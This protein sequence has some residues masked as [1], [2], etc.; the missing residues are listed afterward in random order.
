MK[1]QMRR[2]ATFRAGLTVVFVGFMIVKMIRRYTKV[3]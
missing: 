2:E 3:S 1:K